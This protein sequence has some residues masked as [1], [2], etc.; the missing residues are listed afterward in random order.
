MQDKESSFNKGG[1]YA[2]QHNIDGF[3]GEWFSDDEKRLR[4]LKH[5][6]ECQLYGSDP[7]YTFI[8]VERVLQQWVRESGL[9]E[10]YER[11]VNSLRREKELHALKVLID[12]Y[13]LEAKDMLR[14]LEN[15][16]GEVL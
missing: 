6:A 14:K 10:I 16:E 7:E 11:K 12:R 9:I 13:P 4:F 15:P 8:D 5:T 2:F 1:L 3:Y